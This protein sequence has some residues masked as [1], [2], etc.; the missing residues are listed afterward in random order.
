[1]L[2]LQTMK[3][4]VYIAILLASLLGCSAVCNAQEQEEAQCALISAV[5]RFV[6]SDYAAAK[7]ILDSLSSAGVEDDAVEYYEGLCAICDRNYNEAE[8]RFRKACEMDPGNYWYRD[9]LTN[10]LIG[11]NQVE[12]AIESC[13]AMLRDY[14]K[15]NEI[16]LSLVNLY[17]KKGDFDKVLQTLDT[18]DSVF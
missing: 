9:W 14:P 3:R 4:R 12:Q 6:E 10:V 8:K 13:E 5:E 1:M 16:Y 11:T 2:F 15:K 7:A 17:A 18:I